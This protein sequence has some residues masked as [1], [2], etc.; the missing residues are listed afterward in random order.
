MSLGQELVTARARAGISQTGLAARSGVARTY[1]RDLESGYRGT[2]PSVRVLE[3]LAAALD[4]DPSTFQAYRAAVVASHPDW[5]EAA[6][7]A[8]MPKAANG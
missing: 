4:V 3:Q 7:H 6:Y 1:I 2:R 5:I 8:H